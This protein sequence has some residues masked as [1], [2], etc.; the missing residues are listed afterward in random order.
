MRQVKDGIVRVQWRLAVYCML[1]VLS[2]LL[3]GCAALEALASERPVAQLPGDEAGVTIE[4]VVVW[5]EVPVPGAQVELRTG[6]WADPAGSQVVA[7]AVADAEGAYRMTVPADATDCALGALWPD[8]SLSV[9]PV[10]PVEIP[11]GVTA[12]ETDLYLARELVWLEPA[13]GAETGTTPSLRWEGVEGTAVQ[14]VWVIDAGTAEMV[15]DVEITDLAEGEQSIVLPPLTPERTYLC[16][17]QEWDAQGRL[18]AGFKGEFRVAAQRPQATGEL[19]PACTLSGDPIY[20]DRE[21]GFCFPYPERFEAS[22]DEAGRLVL[23]GP[24]P[25]DSADAVRASLLVEVEWAPDG[26]VLEE[27]VDEYLAQFAGLPTPPIS[28]TQMTLAVQPAE[29]LEVVPGR[30]G[31]SDVW[32]LGNGSLFH[33]MF[34]PSVR[35]YPQA[36][37][38]VTELFALVT[39]SFSLLPLEGGQGVQA[40]LLSGEPT[41]TP[42]T[43]DELMLSLEVPVGWLR[44]G[45]DWVWMPSEDSETRLGARWLDLA[46][47]QEIE[48]AMLPGSSVVL[49]SQPFDVEWGSGNMVTVAVYGPNA[50]ITAVETH[51]LFTVQ[52]DGKRWALDVFTVSPDEAQQIALQP[53]LQHA[54]ETLAWVAR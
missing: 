46:P 26:A 53:I 38:D 9:A 40:P 44:P 45:L 16:E 47:P 23:Y 11:Q 10:T 41:Y 43:I 28:R 27:I 17:V 36:A 19:P 24:A 5:G 50:E 12:L 20:V 42:V 15:F 2:S 13:S 14:R 18:L 3:A 34:M 6:A 37:A 54:V 21:H 4:G 31:S 52:Q 22:I 51:A 49:S 32:M 1:I 48:A 30:E 33:L 7:R 8:G 39:G 25:D 35:E 29:Y